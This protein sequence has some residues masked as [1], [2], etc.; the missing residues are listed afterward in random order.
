M[1]SVCV[2]TPQDGEIQQL[3]AA[4]EQ[5]AGAEGHL[6]ERL[7]FVAFKYQLLIDMV[8]GSRHSLGHNAGRAR[9]APGTCGRGW[10]LF[11]NFQRSF[12]A[13]SRCDQR[14]ISCGA[15]GAAGAGQ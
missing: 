10:Q 11:V 2:A 15:V 3:L 8:R 4:R 12:L 5:G 13:M 7:N 6:H 9:C 1:Q 14:I